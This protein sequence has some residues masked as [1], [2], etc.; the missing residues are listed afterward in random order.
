MPSDRKIDFFSKFLIFFSVVMSGM[1][2]LG[3]LVLCAL[4]LPL[5]EPSGQLLKCHEVR[6]SFQFLY[7]GTKWAPETPVSG[8]S[9]MLDK[10]I[11]GILFN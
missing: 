11:V 5:S 6:S 2:F 9:V 4:F 10:E 7:P 1:N 3:S 8:K